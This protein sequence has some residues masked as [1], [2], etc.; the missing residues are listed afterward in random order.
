MKV[1]I[2]TSNSLRQPVALVSRQLLLALGYKPGKQ[3]V[4]KSSNGKSVLLTPR[5]AETIKPNTILVSPVVAGMLGI[6]DIDLGE[7][8]LVSIEKPR[9]ILVEI[10]DIKPSVDKEKLT[11]LLA[12]ILANKV[13]PT[14]KQLTLKQGDYTVKLQVLLGNGKQ[15]LVHITGNTRIT[16]KSKYKSKI[17]D[18]KQSGNEEEGTVRDEK[19]DPLHE[20]VKNSVATNLAKLGFTIDTDVPVKLR[21]GRLVRIDVRALKNVGGIVFEIWIDC[22]KIRGRIEA[23]EITRLVEVIGSAAKIPNLVMIVTGEASEKTMAIARSRGI[24]VYPLGNTTSIIPEEVGSR[25]TIRLSNIFKELAGTLHGNHE[26]SIFRR[27][28]MI[29]KPRTSYVSA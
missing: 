22:S 10:L 13:V 29:F 16:I 25:I 19:S 9:E 24:L 4:L 26:H 3:L 27:I 21:D 2:E 6:K 1:I 23:N 20:Q 5:I 18:G 14:N 8:Y 17:S 7:V 11:K 28:S 12:S 15:A